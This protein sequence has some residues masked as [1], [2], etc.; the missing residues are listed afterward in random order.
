MSAFKSRYLLFIPFIAFLASCSQSGSS[1]NDSATN[2][3]PVA[4]DASVSG[5]PGETV[6]GTLQAS[7]ADGDPLT[8][9]IVS[10]GTKGVAIIND[11]NTGAYSYSP[12]A[13]AID[14]DSFTFKAN[15]GKLDSNIATVTITD[16]IPNTP[17]SGL[18]ASTGDQR[19]TVNW[20][21]VAGADSYTVYWSDTPGTGTGGT[22]V[23]DITAP[24]FYHDGLSNNGSTYYYVVSAVNAA[25]ESAA[26]TEVSA[27]PADVLLSS[28]SYSDANLS[29]C[30]ATATSGL[31]YVHEVT[32]LGSSCTSKS[33]ADISGLEALTSLTNLNLGNNSIS[34]LSPLQGLTQ[35]TVLAL[36]SNSITDV[37]P[38]FR[39][40]GLTQLTLNSNNIN[41]ISG[42]ADLTNIVT[43]HIYNNSIT[44]ISA[45]SSMN[46]MTELRI[47]N[48]TISDLSPLSG[49][50]SIRTLMLDN[51]N[52]DNVSALSS[53]SSLQYLYLS[54]NNI[55]DVSPLSSL[56]GI[57]TLSVQTNS[58][59]GLNVGNVD[60]L[61][62]LT[63]AT[64]IY[65]GDN[66]TMSCAEL[67]SL[68]SALGAPV[69]PAP[70]QDGVNCTAP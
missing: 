8:F 70:A 5:Y 42:L 25:G 66:V 31:T 30:I 56:T 59:G 21:P 40:T 41:D 60:D 57:L 37:Q 27:T 47:Y 34:D 22:P 44:D 10:Q 29:S 15:D 51:N 62:T 68:I 26:S 38:L 33:I 20:D 14:T 7:D 61:S 6:T 50:S 58:I 28:L 19:V 17:T 11:V 35:I 63:A 43:L 64:H 13:G 24:P 12:S 39:M 67:S 32:T 23:T 69:T 45:L 54:G 3:A 49:L 55:V 53:L 52:I 18:S 9:S 4:T 48:N 16:K 65:L 46:A 1:N 36:S 2:T